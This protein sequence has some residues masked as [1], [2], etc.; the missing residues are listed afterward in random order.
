MTSSQLTA[1]T[2]A[3]ASFS[4][5]VL[6]IGPHPRTLPRG[7]RVYAAAT[8][9][10]VALP[11]KRGA[12]SFCE[13]KVEGSV[14]MHPPYRVL[15][16][17]SYFVG[18][19]DRLRHKLTDV[20]FIMRTPIFIAFVTLA[21][22][23][24]GPHRETP[25][26]FAFGYHYPLKSPGTQFAELPPAVQRTIR[27]ETGGTLIADIQKS[28]TGS[29]RP[30]YRVIFENQVRFP[31]LYVAPDGSVLN[32]DLTIAI[33]APHE[34]VASRTAGASERL[35]LED[36]PPQVVKAIQGQAPDA[37]VDTVTRETRGERGERVV[38]DVTFKDRKHPT[39]YLGPDGT[40]L[41]EPLR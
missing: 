4:W 18:R 1:L 32:P 15:S 21:A 36:L 20:L 37:E 2:R 3:F 27:A 31:P 39:L 8:F 12:P 9:Q 34:V 35:T 23:C 10:S 5:G 14:P 11:R 40:I 16:A 22:G 29:D 6:L 25:P 41:H 33:S 28:E 13:L 7:R 38:Y 19:V 30:F 24:R 17:A 26:E